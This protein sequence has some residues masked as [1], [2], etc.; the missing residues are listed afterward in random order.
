MPKTD[1]TMQRLPDGSVQV[2]QSVLE[3]IKAIIGLFVPVK[4]KY[5]NEWR[6]TICVGNVPLGWIMIGV[7]SIF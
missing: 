7:A 5:D 1:N 4:L 2:S 6:C 3:N